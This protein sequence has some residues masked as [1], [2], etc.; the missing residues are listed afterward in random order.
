M[1]EDT[2]SK[3][4]TEE[5]KEDASSG[6]LE[7]ACGGGHED[8]S[9]TTLILSECLG[10]QVLKH[11]CHPFHSMTTTFLLETHLLCVDSITEVIVFDMKVYIHSSLFLF[12]ETF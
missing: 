4:Q 3:T 12:Y 11:R 1:G 10:A 7:G 5:Q 6:E 2:S 9:A 8:S